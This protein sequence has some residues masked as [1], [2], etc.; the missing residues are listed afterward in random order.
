MALQTI[1]GGANCGQ[2]GNF[3]ADQNVARAIEIKWADAHGGPHG[4]KAV[5][6]GHPGV[7]VRTLNEPIVKRGVA[8]C[9]RARIEQEFTADTL[10]LA[11]AFSALR[12]VQIAPHFDVLAMERCELAAAGG[13]R[14]G[15]AGLPTSDAGRA[16]QLRGLAG[17]AVGSDEV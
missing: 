9:E 2:T 1:R 5:P 17:Q 8:R 4:P 7:Y 14:L 6:R 12:F 15:R 10:V 3:G 11:I 16:G 13:S